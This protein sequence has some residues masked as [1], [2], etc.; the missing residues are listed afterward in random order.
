MMRAAVLVP[1]LLLALAS[2]DPACA[3]YV[4]A[5]MVQDQSTGNF[6]CDAQVTLYVGDAGTALAPSSTLSD[7]EVSATSPVCQWDLVVAGGN[8][9]VAVSAPGFEPASASVQLSSDVC[10]TADAPVTVIMTKR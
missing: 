2:C 6:V 4:V 3:S 5:V 10:G 9:T 7:A 8:Y 1:A